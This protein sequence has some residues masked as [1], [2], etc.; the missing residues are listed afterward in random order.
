MAVRGI[1]IAHEYPKP[2]DDEI[3]QAADVIV[4]M[5]CSPS[6]QSRQR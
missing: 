2:R 3:V 4:I 1:D 5:G 6:P